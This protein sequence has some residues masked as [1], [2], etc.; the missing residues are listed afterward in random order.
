MPVADSDLRAKVTPTE[1]GIQIQTSVLRVNPGRL[2]FDIIQGQDL[3]L[4]LIWVDDQEAEVDL[5]S[6]YT[7]ALKIKVHSDSTTTIDSLTQ[8]D[9]ITLAAAGVN[10]TIGRTAAE[11]AAYDFVRAVWDLEVTLTASGVVRR[12]VGG[13]VLLVPEVTA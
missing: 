7:A 2:D 6:G 4:P 9:G 11:T 1:S 3:A 13:S 12:L 5:S 10:I 8:A